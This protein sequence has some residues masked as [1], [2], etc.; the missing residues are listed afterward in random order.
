MTDLGTTYKESPCCEPSPLVK[1]EKREPEY[2]EL[3]LE[4]DQV[5]KFLDGVGLENGKV[6]ESVIRW[7]IRSLDTKYKNL[8][9]CVVEADEPTEVGAA[10]EEYDDAKEDKALIVAIK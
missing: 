7:K 6:Y 10:E 2:P 5:E 8:T 3:R 9:L 4:G 1:T